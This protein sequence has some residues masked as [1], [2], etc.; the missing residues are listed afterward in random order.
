[1]L[2]RVASGLTSPYSQGRRRIQLIY[3]SVRGTKKIRHSLTMFWATRSF[4]LN[5]GVTQPSQREYMSLCLLLGFCSFRCSFSSVARSLLL[6][7]SKELTRLFSFIPV[8]CASP[9]CMVTLF[10]MA[11]LNLHS[12]GD[13]PWNGG[14]CFPRMA[15][16]WGREHRPNDFPGPVWVCSI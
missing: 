11:L 2:G 6:G 14:L 10:A 15:G 4:F 3:R 16:M 8:S 12:W 9:S 5:S 1:M 7:W 13:R